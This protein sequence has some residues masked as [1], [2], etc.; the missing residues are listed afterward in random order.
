VQARI[1]RIDDRRKR[2]GI[3][4]TNGIRRSSLPG[5][6]GYLIFSIS[7]VRTFC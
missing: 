6:A 4:V 7:T 1:A 5:S 3:G 2:T